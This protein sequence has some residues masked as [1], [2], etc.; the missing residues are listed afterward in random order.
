MQIADDLQRAFFWRFILI[1]KLSDEEKE[2]RASERAEEKRDTRSDAEKLK[3]IDDG[4]ADAVDEANAKLNGE[5]AVE[6]PVE[7]SVQTLGVNVT[8]RFHTIKRPFAAQGVR[9]KW[10]EGTEAGGWTTKSVA[11]PHPCTIEFLQAF[12][13][14]S[15][16]VDAPLGHTKA[17]Q[18]GRVV[19]GAEIKYNK[20]GE[21]SI[22][23]TATRPIEGYAPISVTL[24]KFTAAGE[25]AAAL[26]TLETCANKYLN[27]DKLQLELDEDSIYSDFMQKQDLLGL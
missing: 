5:R 23:I 3:E 12:D 13:A 14:L 11:D 19:I 8:R 6:S 18:I 21:E 15:D 7:E 27:G 4:L 16:F 24:G 25:L 9:L 17:Q 10:A 20:D 2:S 26:E 22:Y 1:A